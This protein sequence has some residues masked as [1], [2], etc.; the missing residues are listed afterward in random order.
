MSADHNVAVAEL[1]STLPQLR[2][3]ARATR[4]FVVLGFLSMVV[5]VEL[6]VRWLPVDRYP[7]PSI[8]SVMLRKAEW[9]AKQPRPDVLVLGDSTGHRGLDMEKLEEGAG[10][11]R[12]LNGAITSGSPIVMR[13]MMKD[14]K[15]KPKHIVV[16]TSPLLLSDG[17]PSEPHEAEVSTFAERAALTSPGAAVVTSLWATYR[18]RFWMRSTVKAAAL[19]LLGKKGQPADDRFFGVSSG[20]E[21]DHGSLA[22][23]KAAVVGGD[24]AAL[25]ASWTSRNV[26][27]GARKA[28]LEQLAADWQRVGADVTYVLMP[29]HS[30]LRALS[31]KEPVAWHFGEKTM[32][33]LA[34]D[35][36]GRVFDCRAA[37]DDTGFYD[38][39]HLRKSRERDDFSRALGAIVTQRPAALEA[40]GCRR[41][42]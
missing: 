36:G 1:D 29:V 9:L 31:E 5:S 3:R 23:E 11:D 38:T 24:A 16:T 30:S 18:R 15:F 27:G 10:V 25:W 20:R 22:V 13:A 21:D 17:W 37:V 41:L 19:Q 2:A 8:Q 34:T 26:E 6:L 33:E 4:A 14:V 12:A 7:V 40:S 42:L 28:A 39:D 32:I 35:H